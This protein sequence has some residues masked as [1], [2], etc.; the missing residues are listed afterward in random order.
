MDLGSIVAHLKL[1][2]SDFNSNLNRATDQI[3]QMSTT[4]Q[5]QFRGIDAVGKSLTATGKTL[6]AAVTVPIAG[7]AGASIKTAAQ[8]ESSMSEVKAITGA[9]GGDF[10][11]LEKQAR[12]L[13]SSTKFSASEAAEGMKYFGMAGY[14]TD[15]ILA[16]MPATLNLAA[17][18]N[19]DLG[20]TCDIVSDAMSGFHMSASETGR[21]TDIL[22]AA[23]TNANTNV[24]LLG[25]SFKY[26]APV[27]G[28]MGYSAEDASIALGLMANAG[29]KGSQGGTALRTA[30][31]NLVHPTKAMQGVMDQLGISMTNSD[32]SSKSLR[33]VLGQLREK[34]STLTPAQQASAAATLFGK[35]AMS[36]M[37]AIINA[38][39]ADYQKLTNAIDGCD[40]AAGKMAATMQD[41]LNGQL[42]ALKSAL[43]GAAISIGNAL[44]PTIKQAVQVIQRLVDWF[45]NLSPA[46]QQFIVKIGLLVAAIGPA[47]MILGKMATGFT[48]LK[49]GLSIL[50]TV[51][52]TVGG[53]ISGLWSTIVTAAYVFIT[54]TLIPA[55]SALWGIMLAHPIVAI[56]AAIAALVAAFIAAWNNMDGFKEFWINL[57]EQVK[58]KFFECV[59]WIKSKLQEWG[60]NLTTFF[61]QTLPNAWNSMLNWFQ[62]LPGKISQWLQQVISN[63]GNWVSQ[64]ASKALECGTKFVDSAIKFISTLPEKI[65]YWLAFAVTKAALWVVNMAKKAKEMGTKFITNAVNAI[66]QLPGKIQTWLTN[67]INKV[68]T[69]VTNMV[70]KAKQ[71]G[72]KFINNAINAIKQLPGKIQTWLTNTINKVTTWATNMAN[73]AK[74]AGQ[75]F[76][77]NVSNMIKQLPGKVANFLTQ[78]I[79]KV[80]SFVSQMASKAR[81]AG[82]K[83]ASNIKSALTSLPGQMASIGR[84]IIQGLI[85]GVTGAAGALYNKMKSIAKSALDG[86]KAALGIKSP[87]RKF[88]DEVGKWIPEGI[89]VG[90]DANADS[91]LNT[92]HNLGDNLVS[93]INIDDINKSVNIPTFG[94]NM[95]NSSNELALLYE[96]KD[97]LKNL[98]PDQV[99]GTVNI[100]L[101][102]DKFNNQRSQDVRGLMTEMTDIVKGQQLVKNGKRK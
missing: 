32:G 70:N 26:V 35:E 2:M 69:W 83:F 4:T 3:K 54:D 10:S 23:S 95:N 91:V 98:T 45:N 76:L 63:V 61:T 92:M 30:I 88:R 51:F 18:A 27:C 67:T 47:L 52:S 89:A 34:F 84:N 60:S 93:S 66:K 13:G 37:L 40:G 49:T 9:T 38:S 46:T 16:A 78:T 96:L 74:T 73:K 71:M 8:F 53:V 64:M 14:K 50:G 42:T 41:N 55:F 68:T 87:S 90:I 6:T 33:D 20:T 17:A 81:Q 80:T 19:T 39:D 94:T 77:N 21:F 99:G 86:A 28:A 100:T 7:I 31:T 62:Q 79:S 44:L 25:E 48:A 12:Q 43:E 15:Q 36:G 82:Q 56:V 101:N 29:I 65:A 102:I 85:N 97:A 11:K 57:W 75:K 72:T 58:Q 59:D 22:A 5:N 1:E 24:E